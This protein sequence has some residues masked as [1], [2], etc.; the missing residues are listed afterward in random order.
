MSLVLQKIVN[1]V[2]HGSGCTNT[3]E[4]EEVKEEGLRAVKLQVTAVIPCVKPRPNPGRF[5]RTFHR[6]GPDLWSIKAHR[7]GVCSICKQAIS[8]NQEITLLE[9]SAFWAHFNHAIDESSFR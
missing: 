3:P 4:P 5:N 1:E 2:L 9:K 8:V 7:E 6:Y